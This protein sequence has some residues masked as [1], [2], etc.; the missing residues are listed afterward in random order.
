M[1]EERTIEEV[2]TNMKKMYEEAI[3]TGGRDGV[4]SLIRSQKLINCIHD[5]IKNEFISMGVSPDK[6]HPGL[7][8]AK[9]E[10]TMAGFLKKK[11][12]DI[13]ILGDNP[14][15]EEIQDG[16]LIG[17][18]DFIGKNVMKK[19][20]TINVRSQLSSLAKNF[21]TLYERTF[22]EALNLKLRVPDMVMGE[23]YL[24]PFIAYDPDKINKREIGWK[25]KLP[26]SYIPAFQAL[27]NGANAKG[28]EYKYERVCLL[29]IDFRSNPPKIIDSID[30]FIEEGILAGEDARKYSLSGLGIDHFVRDILKAYKKKHR[31]ISALK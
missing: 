27:N 22:A 25:E 4:H 21:D 31:G 3:I 12:Q 11:S 14:T 6:I 16:V 30:Y 18:T 9:P 10:L 1:A 2:L 20:I 24:V 15:P 17:E 19:S 28:N 5:Y 23:V 8:Q 13:S 29:I 7:G 26:I